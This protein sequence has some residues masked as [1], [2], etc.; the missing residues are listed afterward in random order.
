MRIAVVASLVTPLLQAQAG[1]AQA[2][3]AD[4]AR[5]LA[6]RGHEVSLYCSAG[7]DIP[8][9]ELVEISVGAG[10]AAARVMPG[11]PAPPPSQAL[12]AGF[13]TLF[14]ELRRRRPDV[15]SQHAFDAEAFELAAGLRV[16]HTLHLPP[17]VPAVVSAALA[18]ARPVVTVSES[19]RRQWEAV[20][21]SCRVIR[22]G[23]P[24]FDPGRP[25]VSDIALIPG[26]ISPEKG[27]EAAIRAA[28]LAG[29]RPLVVGDPYDA[30]YAEGVVRPLLGPGELLPAIPRS[31]LLELMASSAVTLM[32]IEWEEPFG[33]VAA[34]SQLAGCPVVGYRRG[35]LPE[36]VRQGLGG[37]LVDPGDL[38]SFAVAARTV[39]GFDRA[40]V[41][42]QARQ[43]LLIDATITAYEL[44]LG[45]LS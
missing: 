17:L 2:F 15:I 19:C 33:L 39:L 41:R 4:L 31:E 36:V 25:P 27:T 43:H 37:I 18:C 38:A 13:G 16:L 24:D 8:G 14:S 45:G 32:P 26:R 42:R 6:G 35:A 29:L 7:S 20:G 3:L 9:V 10:A 30:A 44:A 40:A 34:E 1:G 23:V 11:G 5:G 21:V 22:N 28:R 12:R